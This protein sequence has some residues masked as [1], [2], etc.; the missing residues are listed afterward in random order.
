MTVIR[1]ST[2]NDGFGIKHFFKVCYLFAF[3]PIFLN[4]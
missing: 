4:V 1:K 3:F 2:P